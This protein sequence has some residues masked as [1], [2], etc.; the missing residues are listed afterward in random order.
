MHVHHKL[1]ENMHVNR[2]Q[3]KSRRDNN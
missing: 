2:W 1:G 3:Q